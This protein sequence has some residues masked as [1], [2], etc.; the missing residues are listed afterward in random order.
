[1]LETELYLFVDLTCF[2]IILSYLKYLDNPTVL[3]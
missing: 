2:F 3:L 1:M